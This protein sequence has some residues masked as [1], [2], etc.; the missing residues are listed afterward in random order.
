[1]RRSGRRTRPGNFPVL[2][3]TVLGWTLSGHAPAPATQN[4]PQHTF[5]LRQD[6]SLEHNLKSFLE[7]KPVEKST[8]KPEQQA[9]EEYFLTPQPKKKMEDSL[10]NFQQR[11][12]PSSLGLFTSADQ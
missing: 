12:I 4:E 8:M 2:Q 7:V 1:M 3:E 11:W 10:L 5:L 6:N 9:C